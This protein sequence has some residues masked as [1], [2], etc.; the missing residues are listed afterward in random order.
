MEPDLQ[1]KY[2]KI[3]LKIIKTRGVENIKPVVRRLNG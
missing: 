3:F 1:T 2:P